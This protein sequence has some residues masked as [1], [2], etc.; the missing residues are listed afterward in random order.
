MTILRNPPEKFLG[1]VINKIHNALDLDE[2]LRII[3]QQIQAFLRVDRVK[4][5][6]F[7]ADGSGEVIAEAVEREHLP[8]LL[9]LHF[10]ASDIPSSVREEIRL[11]HQSI[12]VDISTQRRTVHELDDDFAGVVP[13]P[14][15]PRHVPVD[16]CHIQYLLAMGVLSSLVVPIYYKDLLWGLLAIHHSQPRRFAEQELDTVELLSKEITLAITQSM[17]TSRVEQQ[18]HQEAI[19]QQLNQ[20]LNQA[21]TSQFS[22]QGVLTA[23]LEQMSAEAGLLYLGPDLTGEP[24]QVYQTGLESDVTSLI[25]NPF[26]QTLMRGALSQGVKPVV[27]LESQSSWEL[28]AS[29]R[30]YVSYFSLG[31]LAK[32]AEWEA[33]APYFQATGIQSLLFIPF[34]TQDQW[35][36]CLVLFRREY[37]RVRQWAGRQDGDDRNLLPRL[38]FEVWEEQQRLIPSWTP[39]ELKLGQTIGTHLYMLITQQFLTR[40]IDH[41]TAYDSLTQLP[42]WIIFN[43]RLTLALLDALYQG[44]MLAVLVIAMDRFRRINETLGHGVGDFLLQQVANRLQSELEAFEPH[45]PLL[46]RWHGDGFTLLVSNLSYADEVTAICRRLL[47]SFRHPFYVQGQVLYLTASVGASLA[48]YDGETAEALLKFAETA[49]SQAKYQGKN[50]FQL[51]QPQALNVRLNHLSLETD[52]RRALDRNELLL[53]YQPQIDLQSGRLTGLEVLLRWQHPQLGFI[54]PTEFIPLAEE[55]GL[56]NEIGYWALCTACQQYQDLRHQGFSDLQLAINLSARQFQEANL[57]E[58]IFKV[59]QETGMEP[60]YLELEITESLMMQDV[61]GTVKILHQLKAAGIQVAIDDFGT[62]YSS[63]A[64]LKHLPI[65]RLKIDKSFVDDLLGASRDAAIIQCVIGLGKGLNL[66]VVAEGIETEKQLLQLRQMGCDAAQGYFISR[67]VPAEALATLLAQP[68]LIEFQTNEAKAVPKSA[69]VTPSSLAQIS[70]ALTQIVPGRTDV[71]QKLLEY[72]ALQEDLRQRT[73]REKIVMQIAQKIRSSINLDEILTATVTEVRNFLDTD[74]VILYQFNEKWAGTV[75]VEA[76]NQHCRSILQETIDDPCF[77]HKYIS[78][79]RQGRVRAIADLE[80]SDLAP[81]HRETLQ[82]YQVRANLVVPIICAEHLWGLMIAHHCRGPRPWHEQEIQLLT[83]L[84]T[85]ASIAIHQGELYQQ[86]AAA[87]QQ[88][89]ELSA[90]D[91]LTGVGNRYLFDDYLQREWQRLL[92]SQDPLSLLIC[93]VDY[94]KKFNDTYGHPAGDHGLKRVAETIKSLLKRPS[95]L[96]ARYGGEEFAVILPQTPPEGAQ[97]LA[98]SICEEVQGLALP[99]SQS[100]LGR[101]TLSIGVATLV[102]QEGLSPNDLLQQADLALYQAKQA[103]R[104]Q[105]MVAPRADG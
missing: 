31:E 58:L 6:R 88:L 4:I 13:S 93:D 104:N 39:E 76:H 98:Q 70:Q 1:R 62:G 63:L 33:C 95:D 27:S 69:V 16:P 28:P 45:H 36:G 90:R 60:Q 68:Q 83:E 65:H 61:E 17:L 52:L 20:L 79:Y 100:P 96:V 11:K 73:L 55:I 42:N 37:C 2:T 80:Q 91:A 78:L 92:R 43:Q 24:G 51:Y 44:E 102:P 18:Q 14:P 26:W 72:A 75:V 53:Y 7:G 103:G 67:P 54:S 87:N 48:P 25:E 57:V 21:T 32:Q 8:S 86:L 49:L 34:C 99:H 9:G 10:P 30:S 85:Q 89:Q 74:R 3:V 19:V 38:S 82:R 56:I 5:Y 105:V 22:W 101:V 15:G 47:D 46:S 12:I 29:E 41:Q 77:N 64:I 35:V 94:F 66:A 84:A 59:L 40:L 97:Y 50:T 81:C 71:T 23:C